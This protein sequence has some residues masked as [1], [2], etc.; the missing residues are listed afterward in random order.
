MLEVNEK[1]DKYLKTDYI[2]VFTP[3]SLVKAYFSTAENIRCPE[4]CAPPDPDAPEMPICGS[5]GR[6][7]ETGECGWCHG[8]IFHLCFHM[9]TYHTLS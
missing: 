8:Q 6:T 1:I 7:Y 2:L 3:N 9:I 5:D 4:S